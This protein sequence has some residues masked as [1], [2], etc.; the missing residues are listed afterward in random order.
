M[1][2]SASEER[3]SQHSLI[4]NVSLSLPRDPCQTRSHMMRQEATGVKSERQE[5]RRKRLLSKP[6]LTLVIAI[7]GVNLRR[8]AGRAGSRSGPRM[9]GFCQSNLISLGSSKDMIYIKMTTVMKRGEPP[10]M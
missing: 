6:Y 9:N 5:E 10:N 7:G 8:Q 1:K 4:H 3:P 2:A